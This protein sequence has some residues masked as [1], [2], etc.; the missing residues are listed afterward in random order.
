MI[1]SSASRWLDSAARP[2]LRESRPWAA[3][4]LSLIASLP[5]R[6]PEQIESLTSQRQ[7]RLFSSMSEEQRSIFDA[8]FEVTCSTGDRVIQQGEIGDSLYIVD[9]GRFCAYLRAKGES[10]PAQTYTSGR[11]LESSRSCTTARVRRRSAAWRPAGYG[12]SRVA[13]TRRSCAPRS[14]SLWI[15]APSSSAP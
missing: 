14:T 9:S 3:R 1:V 5:R 4:P 8:M 11:S 7:V 6:H 15:R 12:G 13:C 2:S 10:E